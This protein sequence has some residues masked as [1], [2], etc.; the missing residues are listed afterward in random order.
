MK[1]NRDQP[2]AVVIICATRSGLAQHGSLEGEKLGSNILRVGQYNPRLQERGRPMQ[3]TVG[4][5]RSATFAAA[6]ISIHVASGIDRTPD[7]TFAR[8]N[9]FCAHRL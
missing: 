4:R 6:T 5:R 7:L 1:L 8:W 9:S 3:P 2:A